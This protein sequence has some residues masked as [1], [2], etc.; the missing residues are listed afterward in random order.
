M[1]HKKSNRYYTIQNLF[2]KIKL[3]KLITNNN[4]TKKLTTEI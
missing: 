1:L 2:L 3:E 4:R